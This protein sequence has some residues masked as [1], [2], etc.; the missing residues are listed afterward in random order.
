MEGMI[1]KPDL[2]VPEQKT[3]SL[4]FCDTTPK[5]FRAWIKQLPMAN[6]GE[7]SRQLYHAIIELNHLFLTPQNRLRFLELIR[8]KIHF[9][10]SELS[11]HYLGLAVALPEKQRKIANLSQALQLHLA[12]GYKLCLL[13]ALDDGGLDKNRKLIATAVQRATSELASTILRSHQLYCPSPAQSWLECHRMFRFSHR[14]KLSDVIV[15]DGTLRQRQ[16][17]TVAAS[18]KRLLLLGCARPNQLRQSEL[19]HAYELFESWTEQ[20][21]CGPEI[22]EDTLFVVNMER[23]SSPVYRS[24]LEAKPGDESFGFDTRELAATISENL[25]ARLRQ[26]PAPGTLKIPGNVNDTL[27]THLSQAL[28]ILAKRNFNRI[29][30]QGT[31]EVCVGLSA[32]HYF[33]AG[34][35]SFTEFVTGNDNSDSNEE[36][37]FIRKS[38]KRNDAWSDAHDA[39]PSDEHLYSADTPINFRGSFGNTPAPA[40]DK[41]QPRSHTTLLVNTSPGGYCV[42]WETSV[43]PSMQAG[44]ILGVREQRSHPWSIAVVRWIRQIRNH[45]TQIGI[46]LLAP[47]G[48]PCGV[49][50]IQK[51]GNSSEYLR[52]LMLPEISVANQPA[53]LI[54]P[55][56]PFQS[57]SRISILHDGREEQGQLLKKVSSTGSISQFELKLHNSVAASTVAPP[58]TSPAT[59]EDDFDSLW[60]SL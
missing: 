16:T 22:G 49:R 51:V 55:R 33:I 10:C 35:K 17:S 23:D 2:R 15:E 24:L 36:N 44:E 58:S 40:I 37:L 14:N 45:G 8:E 38:R 39:S 53:T 52:G 29:A 25:D 30:S 19:L 26:L 3:A 12:S 46:E 32:A 20:T 27:L 47:S 5:A 59:T 1:L 42:S 60:P 28:G 56:L 11:R 34:E 4:S 18:Y 48:S 31:L 57:G 54:T 7:V 13:E 41:N 50:L 6:I 21:R 9:V 43:P